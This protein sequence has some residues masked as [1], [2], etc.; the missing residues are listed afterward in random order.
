MMRSL[1]S[2]AAFARRSC[3]SLTRRAYCS[4]SGRGKPGPSKGGGGEKSKSAWRD[5]ITLSR[6]SMGFAAAVGVAAVGAGASAAGLYVASR[7]NTRRE[8]IFGEEFHMTPETLRMPYR[9]VELTTPD[10]V[11][12]GAWWMEQ[13][14][15]GKS[16]DKVVLCFNP[17]NHDKSRLLGLA[18]GL[19]EAGYTVMLF[20]FRS[21]AISKKPLRHSI[22]YLEEIDARTALKFVRENKPDYADVA[23][24]G[25]SMGG[26]MALTLASTEDDLAACCTDCAFASLRDVVNHM[27]KVGYSLPEPM[28]EALLVIVEAANKVVYGYDIAKVGPEK[29]LAAITCPVLIAHSRDDSIVPVEHASRIFAGVSTPESE[30]EIVILP[31]YKH[32]GAYFGDEKTYIRRIVNFLEGVWPRHHR[33]QTGESPSPSNIKT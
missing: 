30:K 14:V 10:G 24:V 13:T 26:A 18:R 9:E 29:N 22:G 11:K 4:S 32:I 23:F 28:R 27:I 7:L 1:T 31:G 8:R 15:K 17:Y 25:A 19:W 5:Y 3:A 6:Y 20:D 16:S 12:L 2:T 21:H 33:R